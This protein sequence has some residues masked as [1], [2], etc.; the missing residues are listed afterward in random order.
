MMIGGFLG[1]LI[2]GMLG[3]STIDLAGGK[4]TSI[5]CVLGLIAGLVLGI[6]MDIPPQLPKDLPQREMFAVFNSGCIGWFCGAMLAFI[7]AVF[8]K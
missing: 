5:L 3:R 7:S 8:R 1:V 4:S 6:A 2:G